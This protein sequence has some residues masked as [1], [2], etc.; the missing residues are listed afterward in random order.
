MLKKI[1]FIIVAFAFFLVPWIWSPARDWAPGLAV[2]AGI[3]FSVFWGNPF[4][5]YTSKITSNLLG[6]TIVGMGFGMNLIAVL[7]SGA[8]GFLYTFIGIALGIG[9]GA[10]LGKL[11]K[12]SQKCGVSGQR[13]NLYLRRKCHCGSGSGIEGETP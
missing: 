4:V 2:L 11:L 12:V 7:R 6:A 5:Q 9:L 8:N 10:L 13:G 1:L 3:L